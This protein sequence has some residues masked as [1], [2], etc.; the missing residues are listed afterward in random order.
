M[1]PNTVKGP[2]SDKIIAIEE[3]SGPRREML[4]RL[5]RIVPDKDRDDKNLLRLLAFRLQGSGE[6]ATAEFVMQ[7]MRDKIRAGF[8]G[9]LYAFLMANARQASPASMPVATDPPDIA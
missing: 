4:D 3:R 5:L 9:S 6:G 1:P 2:P 7:A 8:T